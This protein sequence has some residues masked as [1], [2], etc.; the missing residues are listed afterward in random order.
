[1]TAESTPKTIEQKPSQLEAELKG[2]TTRYIDIQSNSGESALVRF[3]R[4]IKVSEPKIQLRI[5]A[6]KTVVDDDFINLFT[7]YTNN[8]L[9][10]D[11]GMTA[12]NRHQTIRKSFS[13]VVLMLLNEGIKQDSDRLTLL[14]RRVLLEPCTKLLAEYDA[15]RIDPGFLDEIGAAILRRDTAEATAKLDTFVTNPPLV[16]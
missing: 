3:F 9:S 14:S 12:E 5:A 10:S 11:D 1:M 4:L 2:L 8:T 15:P 13:D 16:S 6:E 7:S